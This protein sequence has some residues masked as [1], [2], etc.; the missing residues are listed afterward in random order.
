M[1]DLGTVERIVAEFPQLRFEP[2]ATLAQIEA[3]EAGLGRRL[4]SILR[5]LYL[6]FNGLWAPS[7]VPYLAP[8]VVDN[9]GSVFYTKYLQRE[10]PDA[11]LEKFVFFGASTQQVCWAIARDG[12]PQFIA[13]AGYMAEFQYL[14]SDL[15]AIYRNDL[16]WYEDTL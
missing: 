6:R 5:A 14:G 10:F 8:L 4:P 16:V 11:G 7:N 12:S 13:F 2:P 1:T 15:C 9:E 3:A